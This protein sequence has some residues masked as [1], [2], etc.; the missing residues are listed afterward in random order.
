MFRNLRN[1]ARVVAI[2]RCL[3]RH[4]A[5]FPLDLLPLPGVVRKVAYAVSNK[6]APGRPGERLARALTELGPAFV[7]LGQTLA[8][9]SD[10][11]G[12][13]IA[14]D[15]SSLQDRLP[16]FPF[17]KARAVIEADLERP[18]GEVFRSFDETPVAAASI[19][20]VHFAVTTEGEDVAVKVL[21]PGIEAAIDKDLDLLLWLAEIV[22]RFQ[23]KLRRLRPVATVEM[24]AVTT[25]R[26]M[27]LRFEASA[28]T[29]FARNCADD[30]G[31]RVPKVDWRRTARRVATFERIYGLP[32]NDRARLIREGFDPDAILER[33]AIVFFNQL[34]RDGF[35][36]A[37][38][39][40][41]NMLLDRH[42]DIV[43]LDFGIMGRIDLETRRNLAETL[44]G[45]LFRQYERVADV[46]FRAGYVPADQDRQAFQQACRAIG[47]P[48]LGL[49]L[50]DIS[51][52]RLLGQL[53]TVAEQF[54]MSQQPQLVLLQKTIVVSEGVGRT[55]NPKVN[56]WQ[57]AQPLVE[58]WIRTN[59]GPEAKIRE[60]LG[61][62]VQ[63]FLK[64]PE[65][66][67][68][69]ERVLAKLE[70]HGA[71]VVREVHWTERWW[72]ILLV[73]GVLI[74]LALR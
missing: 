46:F 10:L 61:E 73:L 16:S 40:P 18:L 51:I 39:H 58:R 21:R 48:I 24:L 41:G 71:A 28:A 35:F 57:V 20:Q 36:H 59:L 11:L 7:K 72:P 50:E 74:G 1:G 27:D 30:E 38:M 49:P 67:M 69:S 3:A 68:R 6:S 33:A 47:E 54:E 17:G 37:D 22:E 23:P 19:A 13:A 12:D 25:R 53:L 15:L 52:G 9:R 55:L 66:V 14:R 64:L 4:N 43:A 5:L 60:G 65:L 8:V 34:F 44:L 29:E 62:G 63:A 2:V 70:R 26:E 56:I 32:M 31:F 42:G 45:F